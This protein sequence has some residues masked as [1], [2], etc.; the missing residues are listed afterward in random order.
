MEFRNACYLG[1]KTGRPFQ[2]DVRE[3]KPMKAAKKVDR[4]GGGG[5]NG[6][7]AKKKE[8]PSKDTEVALRKE[9]VAPAETPTSGVDSRREGSAETPT[10]GVD[11]RREASITVF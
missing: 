9:M 4:D 5:N 1:I 11:S 10:S 7:G 2:E 6:S 8:L 3:E